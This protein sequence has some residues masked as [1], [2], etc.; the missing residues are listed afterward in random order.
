M[1]KVD[2]AQQGL[3]RRRAAP[4]PILAGRLVHAGARAK[5][6][7]DGSLRQRQEHA[8]LHTGSAGAARRGHGVARRQGSVSP[9]PRRT[10][11]RFATARS[12]SSSRTIACCRSAPCSRTCSRRRSWPRRSGATTASAPARFWNRSGSTPGSTI[13]RPSFPAA[14]SSALPSRAPSSC[15][16]RLLLCDEPTGNLDRV[17]AAAVTALL[18]ELHQREETILVVVTHSPDLASKLPVRFELLGQQLVRV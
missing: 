10:W 8:A 18:L 3:S 13:A 1:L 14:R 4:L 6:S 2:E 16:P 5:R 9:L 17:S 12:A 11:R 15:N 7:R